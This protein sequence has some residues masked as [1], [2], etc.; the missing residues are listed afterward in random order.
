MNFIIIKHTCFHNVVL[1]TVEKYATFRIEK[2][3]LL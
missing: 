1:L 2:V 3:A